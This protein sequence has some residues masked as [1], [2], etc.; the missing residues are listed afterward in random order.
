MADVR[1]LTFNEKNQLTL[2]GVVIAAVPIGAPKTLL[3]QT[4]STLEESET[5]DSDEKLFYERVVKLC[6]AEANAYVLDEDQGDGTEGYFV[7]PEIIVKAVQ[8]YRTV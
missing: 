1:K 4:P 6:P 7:T 5:P 2:D 8:Y 3:T